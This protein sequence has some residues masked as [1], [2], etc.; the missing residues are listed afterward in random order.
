MSH[1][2]YAHGRPKYDPHDLVARLK[3]DI[4]RERAAAERRARRSTIPDL[5][6]LTDSGDAA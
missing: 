6:D 1:D 2:A 4:A 5:D 3:A